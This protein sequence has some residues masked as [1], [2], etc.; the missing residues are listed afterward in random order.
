MKTLDQQQYETWRLDATILEQDRH[1]EKVLKLSDGT[2]LKLFR[3]KRWLSKSLFFPPA[4][5]FAKNAAQLKSLGIPCPEVI[6]THRLRSPDRTVVHYHPLPGITLRELVNNSTMPSDL[7]DQLADFVIK[8]HDLGVYF[9]SLH[10][11]NILLTP[12][13]QFGLIDISD[14]RFK[15]KPLSRALRKRNLK[16]LMRYTVD[17]EKI[18]AATRQRFEKH[19]RA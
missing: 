7:M 16:H 1:G 9:R 19:C 10:L 13:H 2:L 8:L 15:G 14:M 17:W 11:G 6:D 4:E 5:R 3:R 18:D 12:D